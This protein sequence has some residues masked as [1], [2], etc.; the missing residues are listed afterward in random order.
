MATVE[1]QTN[2]AELDRPEPGIREQ[3]FRWMLGTF[4]Q[5]ITGI[6]TVSKLNLLEPFHQQEYQVQLKRHLIL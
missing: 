5:S 4:L 1:E 2:A 6:D 3:R